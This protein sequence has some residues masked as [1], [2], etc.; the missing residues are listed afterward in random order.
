MRK[1]PPFSRPSL[2]WAEKASRSRSPPPPAVSQ[3]SLAGLGVGPRDLSVGDPA[4]GIVAAQPVSLWGNVNNNNLLQIRDYGWG[5]GSF[6]SEILLTDFLS[7]HLDS[8]LGDRPSLGLGRAGGRGGPPHS[9]AGM[10]VRSL[11]GLF[12]PLFFLQ[13]RGAS[14]S[15]WGGVAEWGAPEMLLGCGVSLGARLAVAGGGVVVALRMVCTRK[16]SAC[17][18]SI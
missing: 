8:A 17:G 9:P 12:P 13:R 15:P 7:L 4:P 5:R 10:E 2:F 3:L 11:V 16:S 18:V 6:D 1:L 14:R